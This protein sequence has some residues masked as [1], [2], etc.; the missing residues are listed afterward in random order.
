MLK[1]S[2]TTSFF[3]FEN[4]LNPS[5]KSVDLSAESQTIQIV[6]FS[7]FAVFFSLLFWLNSIIISITTMKKI[8]IHQTINKIILFLLYSIKNYKLESKCRWM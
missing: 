6:K 1:D 2:I 4:F 8:K 5:I 3:V 7:L